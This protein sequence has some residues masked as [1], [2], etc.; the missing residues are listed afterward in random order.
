M[1]IG[2]KITERN[3]KR[4]LTRASLKSVELPSCAPQGLKPLNARGFSARLKRVR[5]NAG[6]TF[7]RG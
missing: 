1:E 4:E 6:K 2:H 7:F 3:E 5:K